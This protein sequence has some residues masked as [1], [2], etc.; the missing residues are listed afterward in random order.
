VHGEVNFPHLKLDLRDPKR[1]N[2][3]DVVLRD[4]TLRNIPAKQV[5]RRY[6]WAAEANL[7]PEMGG[8]DMMLNLRFEK[9][10]G[11]DEGQTPAGTNVCIWMFS[12]ICCS[13]NAEQISRQ[14]VARLYLCVAV[15][16]SDSGLPQIREEITPLVSNKT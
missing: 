7:N 1:A 11:S 3:G 10:D 4:C 13:R 2:R 15:D 16:N 6:P 14:F 5:P 9:T 8:L 12:E